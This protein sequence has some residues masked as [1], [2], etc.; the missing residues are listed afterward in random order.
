MK[1]VVDPQLRDEQADFR[2]NKSCMDQ[3]ATLRIIVEQYLEWNSSLYIN[4]V[5]YE[6]AF[7]SVDRAVLWKLLWHYGI[8]AK[9]VHLIKSSY[10]G[11]ACGVIQGG[12]LINSFQVKTGVRQGCLLSPFLFLIT[13]N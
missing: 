7:D 12:Q 2:Q 4:L 6:K 10:K 5:I 8:P 13:I 9:V 3:I 1:D 11:M